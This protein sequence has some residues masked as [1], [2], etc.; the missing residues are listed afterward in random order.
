M[1]VVLD[2]NVFISGIF[3]DGPPFQILCAWRDGGLQLLISEKIL[4]EYIRVADI[5]STRYPQID[6]GP[7]LELITLEA[8]FVSAP[9][10]PKPV[11]ADPDD[12]KFLECAIAGNARILVSGDKHL[13]RISDFC[14][15]EII[16]PRAFV[17]RFF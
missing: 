11:C 13:L 2:T 16:S 7:V 14:G 9:N 5:L 10:L 17:N 15:V 8:E 12:D 1:K 3:F 4:E 6:L